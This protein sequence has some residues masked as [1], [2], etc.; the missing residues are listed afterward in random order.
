MA[1]V[2]PV[3][4]E[5]KRAATL[6]I[7]VTGMTCASCVGHV[8]KALGR[9]PGVAKVGVNL[10]TERAD[11]AFTG[12]ADAAAV[13][14]AIEGAGYGVPE[15]TVELGVAGMTCASCV[16]HVESALK[17]VPGVKTATVN[18]A[19]ERVSVR[20]LAGVASLE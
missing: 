16:A 12:R 5:V 8:E 19:T 11:I 7:P 2:V 17:S 4:R 3:Q 20:H 10:A 15:G 13:A 1:D 14:R 6:S 9:L 18:L